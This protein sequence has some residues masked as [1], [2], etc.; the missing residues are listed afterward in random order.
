M[1]D[2]VWAPAHVVGAVMMI[3]PDG[4]QVPA[5]EYGYDGWECALCGDLLGGCA[6]PLAVRAGQVCRCGARVGEVK[7][8]AAVAA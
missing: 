8:V 6:G 1:Q 4:D 3:T 5:H 2:V 7:M